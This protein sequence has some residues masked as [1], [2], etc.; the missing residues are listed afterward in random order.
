M[1]NFIRAHAQKCDNKLVDTQLVMFILKRLKD[2]LVAHSISLLIKFSDP[3]TNT[4]GVLKVRV[5]FCF[6][7]KLP[8]FLIS[9]AA[10]TWRPYFR[11]SLFLK[12]VSKF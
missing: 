4:M 5:K 3:A 8:L 9:D 2:G 10:P 11:P 12:R 6:L 1:T 7:L